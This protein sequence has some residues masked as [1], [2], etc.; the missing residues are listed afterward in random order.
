MPILHV[1][2]S[3]I[4]GESPDG[5]PISIPPSAALRQRGPCLQATISLLQTMAQALVEQGAQVPAPVS[6]IALLD[7]GASHTCVDE[8]IAQQLGLP[9][10]DT[11]SMASASHA[12]AQRNV[13]P[14]TVE[15][16]G[17][18]HQIN[19]AQAIGADLQSQGL[20]L[21]LGRDALQFCTLFYNGVTG[22]ITIAL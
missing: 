6:G 2:F 5:Q 21:L 13:Y 3:A 10:V 1:Q 19:V 9:A 12:S 11:V 4:E 17:L 15:I 7:T 22:G 18:P 16:A 20:V 8:Q 14:I